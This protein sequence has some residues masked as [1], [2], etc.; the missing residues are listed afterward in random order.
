[1]ESPCVKL[2]NSS[3]SILDGIKTG[4]LLK[5][6]S[7]HLKRKDVAI[8]NIYSTLLDAV[9]FNRDLVINSEAKAKE[10]GEWIRSGN[11][12]EKIHRLYTQG[13]AAY[14]LFHN[15]AK[16]ADLFPAKVRK[17]LH[18]KSSYVKFTQATTRF[19]RMRVFARFQN[20]I[21]CMD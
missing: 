14:G 9:R 17:F 11:W 3:R 5:D 6:S 13:F 16:A 7:K 4:V 21:W 20:E 19:K 8:P 12:T 1:M 10:K 18:S 15:V 2:S